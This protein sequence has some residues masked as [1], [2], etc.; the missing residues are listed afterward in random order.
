MSLTSSKL[1]VKRYMAYDINSYI[2]N[3]SIFL[4]K[5]YKDKLKRNKT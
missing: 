2:H 4:F 5:D 3:N 1:Y